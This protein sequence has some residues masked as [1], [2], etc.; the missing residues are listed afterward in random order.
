MKK[1]LSVITTACI[2]LSM[3]FVLSG[4]S[5][6][7][8]KFIGK[9]NVSIDMTDTINEQFAAEEEVGDYLK[10]KEFSLPMIFTFRDDGTYKLEADSDKF[11]ETYD[12]LIADFKDGMNKYLEDSIKKTGVDM[13]ADD[14]LKSQGITMDELIDQA[15]T[16]DMFNEMV[17][18]MSAKGN[19]KVE[20]GKLYT[21]SDESDDFD[22]DAYD[23]Y[24]IVSDSE[25]ELTKSVGA[26]DEETNK[27][28]PLT[29]KKR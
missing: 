27:M 6:D 4:C 19:Y 22:D 16:E 1:V 25:I 24:K 11:S 28:Y 14:L 18:S 23:E 26:D 17:S 9:W 12:N 5:S 20:D 15:F 7:A 8:E 21:T 29:L 2:L 13:T 3:V 10:V